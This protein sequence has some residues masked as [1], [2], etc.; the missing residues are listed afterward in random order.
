M[1]P[2]APQD[3]SIADSN[4]LVFDAKGWLAAI[5]SSSDDAIVG[6]RLDGTIVSWNEGAARLFGY[7]PEEII[8]RNVLTLIPPERHAEEREIVARLSRGERV[9]HFETIRVRKDGTRVEVS[10]AV[11]PIRDASGAIVGAAKIARDIGEQRNLVARAEAAR[12]R[13][14][15][16]AAHIER[17]QSLT[18]ALSGVTT[19]AAVA[20]IV[21]REGIASLGAYA[22]VVALLTAD[23]N[24]LELL[25]SHGYP[26]EA[27]MSVGRRWPLD[28][29]IPIAEAARTREPVFV[30][31]PEE[32]GARYLGGYTPKASESRAWAAVPLILEGVAHGALLWTYDA[33]RVFDDDDR[34]LMLAIARQAVQALERT[35]LQE[36]ERVAQA[37]AERAARR[38]A[39]LARASTVL[40]SSLD[41]RSTL[42]AVAR[43]AVPEL[44][45][46]SFVEMLDAEGIPRPAAIHHRDEAK[47]RLAWDSLTQYPIRAEN[48]FGSMLIARTGQP[49]LVP[50]IP[51]EVFESVAHD[52]EHLRQLREL[53]FRSSMQ[54][55]LRAR[56]RL[57]GVLTFA[58]AESGRRYGPA[59]LAMAEEVATRVS[60]ALENA[61]LYEA[62]RAARA[63]AEM[64]AARAEEASRAKSDFLA[65]MSHEL[66]TPLNA[67]A[68][69]VQLIELEIAGPVTDQQRDYL[70]R[71]RAS[72]QHLLGLINDV[73]DLSKIDSGQFSLEDEVTPAAEAIHAAM[74]IAEPQAEAR[75]LELVHEDDAGGSRY[76]GDPDRVRQILVNLLSNAVKFT[77]PPGR[78]TVRAGVAETAA[79]GARVGGRGPWTFI[80]VSDTGIGISPTLQGVVFDP[81]V[82]AESGRTRTRGGTGLGL[83][84]SR[85]L[86]RLMGG[87]ITLESEPGKGSTFTLWLRA[88]GAA[89]EGPD[90]GQRN[91]RTAQAAHLPHGLA[92]LGT[93][94]RTS[95]DSIA[96]A[97]E[98][99]LR[100]DPL[101]TLTRQLS[102]AQIEDHTLAFLADVA[103]SL[104][105]VD[106]TGGLESELLMHGSDIQ[107]AIAERHGVQRRHLGFTAAQLAREYEIFAEVLATRLQRMQNADADD[108]T[109]AVGVVTRLIMHARAA[110][111][112]AYRESAAP[113]G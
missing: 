98:A 10:L 36:S 99:R 64:E 65:T 32:W 31:S 47:V 83:A 8:G 54:V 103:Q 44:A 48:Q 12:V 42:D 107:R 6:K 84:I 30:A 92:P 62:E 110:A 20:R 73:L 60:A 41:V 59:D 87:D 26:E 17:L 46:W 72:S 57:V 14:E 101:F 93:E 81:F 55:P 33:P 21:M 35:R 1:A 51:P 11:S 5:V 24:Q 34:A 19:R 85:R 108:L 74:V 78:I 52:P 37:Q 67:V 50:E 95:L 90:A 68:G 113:Q 2:S 22:G 111:V 23:R 39:F 91:G 49:E 56:G 13:A 66:R 94:L 76:I 63:A 97:W 58:S 15:R 88:P 3:E 96:E 70:T 28:A 77:D 29:A 45:D 40:A 105:I 106:Q 43:L 89:D 79:P 109:L 27:C 100:A 38:V 102:S 18:A 69:Y 82:Q 25:D 4:P 86:A 112:R 80:A 104:V 71:L 61:E 7:R 9:E 53:G 75:S 16:A